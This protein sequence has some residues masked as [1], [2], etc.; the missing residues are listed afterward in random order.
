MN[1]SD[2]IGHPSQLHRVELHRLVGGKGDGMRLV[3][4]DDGRGLSFTVSADRC[5]DISRLS[6]RGMNIGFFA[7]CGYV[8]PQ[9]YD[10]V[11]AGF[12]KSFTAGFMTTCGLT[13]VGSPCTDEGQPLPLHGTI[14]NTPA[15][16]LSFSDDGNV[17]RISLTV[18]DAALFADKL[19]LTRE[20]VCPLDGSGRIILHDRVENIGA[21]QTPY[22][23]LY[24]FN[25]GYP[26]LS[27]CAE[28]SIPSRQT[29]P[30]NRRAAE[31]LN[32]AFE[33]TE[34]Q[35]DFEEQC[36]YHT[37]SEGKVSLTD[38]ESGIRVSLDFDLD[39]LPF[40]TQWKLMQRGEYVLGLEPG[41][42]TPDGR[43]V[44]RKSGK[45][46]FLA[47]GQVAEQTVTVT[48]ENVN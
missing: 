38:P 12:L 6:W 25:F 44:L 5:G 35:S 8:S 2:Y 15:E 37:L 3:Q 31:G 41:N 34:P 33:I 27:P 9:Y 23:I 17:I 11:G 48:L 26:M 4:A 28:L 24:H 40:F 30:R 45:L 43:D 10:P 36:Y 47:P 19:V 13:A 1:L 39:A 7:P 14:A 18:R 32:T 29:A 22:M 42:C 20:Y 16:N 21:K 46:K